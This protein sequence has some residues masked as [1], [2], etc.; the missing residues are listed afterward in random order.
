MR[1]SAAAEFKAPMI[2]APEMEALEPIQIM[3]PVL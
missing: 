3:A 2:I 1:H